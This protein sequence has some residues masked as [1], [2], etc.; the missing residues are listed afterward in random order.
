MKPFFNISGNG[1]K[2]TSLLIEEFLRDNN[3]FKYSLSDESTIFVR[4]KDKT[5]SPVSSANIIEI[6][7]DFIKKY[8][9]KSKEEKETIHSRLSNMGSNIRTNLASWLDSVELQFIEDKPKESYFFFK[10]CIAKVTPEAISVHKYS[11]IEGNVWGKH[12]KDVNFSLDLP[13]CHAELKG[14]YHDFLWQISDGGRNFDSLISIIGY[15]VHRYKDPTVQKAIII[16]DYNVNQNNPNGSTGKTL[17]IK[18]FEHI[19]QVIM[20]QNDIRNPSNRF[21]LARVEVDT[22][23]LVFDDALQGLEFNR[24]FS[25]ITGDMII[26]RKYGDRTA[27]PHS[28]SPKIIFSTNFIIEGEGSSHTRRRIEFF[29]S[30]Y[31]NEKDTPLMHY[32]KKFFEKGEG[33]TDE[34][35][36]QFYNTILVCCQFFLQKGLIEPEL[37]RHY[38]L[39]KSSAPEG[40]INNC[41]IKLKTSE[42]YNKTTLFDEFKVALPHLETSNQNTFTAI[43]KKYAMYKKWKVEETHSGSENFIIF[44]SET[45]ATSESEDITK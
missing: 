44:Y 19:R 29:I 27:I 15:A 4:V 36:N 37:D 40:F 41:D 8:K 12:I 20:E 43:L 35:F 32:E 16:Y 14:S 18:S 28:M 3:F 34:D 26:E 21:A 1:A 39:L 31:F 22:N 11:E 25:I 10:N 2:I 17:L 30:D 9:F 42:R 24:F 38:Y 33:W 6:L 7:F 45:E 13:A 5:V 23:V